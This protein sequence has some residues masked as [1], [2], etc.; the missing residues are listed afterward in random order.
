MAALGSHLAQRP[1][2]GAPGQGGELAEALGRDDAEVEAVG[3]EALQVAQLRHFRLDPLGRRR[4]GA[5]VQP[6]Q[7]GP[8]RRRAG[9][10]AHKEY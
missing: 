3:A 5:V 1:G 4:G 6:H 10:V 2:G 8:T 7:A 9:L